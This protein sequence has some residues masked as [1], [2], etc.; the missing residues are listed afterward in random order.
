MDIPGLSM[1]Q[2][3]YYPYVYYKITVDMLE[4]V[5]R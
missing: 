4:Q 1:P 3:E 2:S 5:Q